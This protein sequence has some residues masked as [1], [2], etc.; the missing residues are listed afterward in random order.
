M[1]TVSTDS[2]QKTIGLRQPAIIEAIS[3]TEA[4]YNKRVTAPVSFAPSSDVIKVE[5]SAPANWPETHLETGPMGDVY[6]FDESLSELPIYFKPDA[7]DHHLS[8]VVKPVAKSKIQFFLSVYARGKATEAVEL[9]S[10]AD[11]IGLCTELQNAKEATFERKQQADLMKANA[12]KGQKRNAN[13]FAKSVSEEYELVK[14]NL[15]IVTELRDF[16]SGNL[17]GGEFAVTVYYELDGS[18]VIIAKT[19]AATE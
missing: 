5:I 16:L 10:H 15:E 11:A 8:V 1:L 3:L 7:P 13:S 14:E 17:H 19:A 6:E 4:K 2:Q 18:R 12:P 9:R